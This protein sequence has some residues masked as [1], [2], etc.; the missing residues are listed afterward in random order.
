MA[1]AS[2]A[3]G[4]APGKMVITTFHDKVAAPPALPAPTCP[5]PTPHL[6]SP[7]SSPPSPAAPGPASGGC[8][9]VTRITVALNSPAVEAGDQPSPAAV[10]GAIV[11]Q[12]QRACC[13]AT[14]LLHPSPVLLS[15]PRAAI[16]NGLNCWLKRALGPW[17]IL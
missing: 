1:A 2:I 14:A 15:L 10:F 16:A 8:S 9:A 3:Q 11:Y 6:L 12:C 4:E 7:A 17:L 13:N 5:N